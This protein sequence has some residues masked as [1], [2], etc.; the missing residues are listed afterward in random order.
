MS[1][2]RLKSSLDTVEVGEA[3][4]IALYCC[5]IAANRPPDPLPHPPALVVPAIEHQIGAQ[6]SPDRFMVT[7]TERR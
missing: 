5:R 6:V 4:D 2:S 1:G 7:G 3:R